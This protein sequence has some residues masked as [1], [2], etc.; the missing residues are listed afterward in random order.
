MMVVDGEG[1]PMAAQVVSATPAEVTLLEGTPEEI[2]VPRRS[3]GRPKKKPERMIA[4]K[5]Y[6]SDPLR[7]RLWE[8]GIELIVPTRNGR[9]TLRY[10]GRK[11]RRYR[12][13]FKIERTFAWLNAFRHLII[14]HDRY[15]FM[16]VAFFHLACVILLLR[17]L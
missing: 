6:D 16:Y 3:R 12:K 8:R 4:D 11:M 2:R 15:L 5:A 10:D 14:R 9:M 17:R 7:D 1:L 13:R